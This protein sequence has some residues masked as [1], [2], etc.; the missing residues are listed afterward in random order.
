M[1]RD[2]PQKKEKEN[3]K[4]EYK[5]QGLLIFFYNLSARKRYSL[6]RKPYLQNGNEPDQLVSHRVPIHALLQSQQ[7]EM[8]NTIM[9]PRN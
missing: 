7:K 1:E 2:K 4:E 9:N 8:E 6:P 5:E 3:G